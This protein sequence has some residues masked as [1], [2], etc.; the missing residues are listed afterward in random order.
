VT[1]YGEDLMTA[2]TLPQS[3]VL[4]C[5]L[6][7]PMDAEAAVQGEFKRTKLQRA[8]HTVLPGGWSM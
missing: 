1:A 2:D 5:G 6:T 8:L 3:A 7:P 4:S